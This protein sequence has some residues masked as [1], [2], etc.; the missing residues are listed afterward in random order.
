M[1]PHDTNARK[2]AR[3]HATPLI[4]MGVCLAIVAVGFLWWV[5]YAFQGQDKNGPRP[6]GRRSR[7]PPNERAQNV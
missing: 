1:A 7:S 6:S 3:R 2:E 4:V 5:V